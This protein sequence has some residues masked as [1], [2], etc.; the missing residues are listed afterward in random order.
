MY[1]IDPRRQLRLRLAFAIGV[2]GI[3]V[4]ILALLIA[5]PEVTVPSEVWLWA[6]FALAV[7]YFEWNSVEVNDRL[8]ASPSVM[9]V[10]TAAVVFGDEA[11]L[12]GEGGDATDGGLG[13]LC[14]YGA[15]VDGPGPVVDGPV[16]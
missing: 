1:G 4:A 7:V 8:S 6:L 15:T 13:D 16:D 9:V 5:L 11:L 12:G 14:A 2:G 3:G 10:M